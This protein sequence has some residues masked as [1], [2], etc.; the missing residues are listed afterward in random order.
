MHALLPILK[1]MARSNRF[2]GVKFNNINIIGV[3]SAALALFFIASA[4]AFG[5]EVINDW[6]FSYAKFKKHLATGY[7][8]LF[9][10]SLRKLISVS[11]AFKI[12]IRLG[13]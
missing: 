12:L 4:I 11:P 6:F 13:G 7:F 5:F 1:N 2:H 3:F 9:I 10:D 8:V